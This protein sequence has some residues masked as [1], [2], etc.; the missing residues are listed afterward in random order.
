MAGLKADRPV[1]SPLAGLTD[2]R[3]GAWYSRGARL[4]FKPWFHTLCDPRQDCED[5]RPCPQ[6]MAWV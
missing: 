2:Q 3:E 5:S 6:G 1:L 4:R